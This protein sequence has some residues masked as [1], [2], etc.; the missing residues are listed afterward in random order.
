MNSAVKAATATSAIAALLGT[1]PAQYAIYPAAVII[2]CNVLS[3]SIQPPP[4]SSRWSLPYKAMT[5][6][7]MNIGWA[8][9]RIQVGVTGVP[10]PRDHAQ[11]AKAVL[12]EANIP[13]ITEDKMP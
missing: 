4:P 3:A 1:V 6:L 7:G 9:N 12:A 13:V 8:V 2:L 10:V 5:V 11:A